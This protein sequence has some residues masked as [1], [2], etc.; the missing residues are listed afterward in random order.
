MY[1]MLQISILIQIYSFENWGAN[2]QADASE[3]VGMFC[4]NQSL[5]TTAIS[6]ILSV[7]EGTVLN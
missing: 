7:V 4:Y 6:R 3:S 1:T 5:G 2:K